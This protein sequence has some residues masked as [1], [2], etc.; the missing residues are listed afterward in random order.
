GRGARTR[1]GPTTWRRCRLRWRADWW[2]EAPSRADLPRRMAAIRRATRNICAI[3][4]ST[5]WG[6]MSWRVCRN[7]SFARNRPGFSSAPS[8]RAT[9][10][11]RVRAAEG[12]RLSVGDAIDLYLHAPLGELGAAADERRRALHP[13]PIVTYIVDR[14]V[15]YTNVC[16][17][18]CKFC[19]FYRPPGHP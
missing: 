4:S 15:N 11:P 12:E 19:N 10:A 13:T 8:R 5:C 7:I 3:T 6:R 9:G 1:S 14:N 17:T 2:R 16:V 18:R